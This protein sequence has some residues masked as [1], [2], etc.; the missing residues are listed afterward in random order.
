MR[1][2][3]FSKVKKHNIHSKILT[4]TYKKVYTKCT[5]SINEKIEKLNL[6]QHITPF[7]FFPFAIPRPS[8]IFDFFYIKFKPSIYYINSKDKGL[9][10]TLNIHELGLNCPEELF[11]YEFFLDNPV[12]FYK[13]A[14]H[15]YYPTKK[16]TNDK[17]PNNNDKS[18][19]NNNNHNKNNDDNTNSSNNAPP[20]S[21]IQPSDSHKLL[22]MLEEKK[23]LL[24]V[25][26][27]N[28]DGLETV[29]GVS[30]KK[31]IHAHGSLRHATC[32]ICRNKVL[33]NEIMKPRCFFILIIAIFRGERRLRWEKKDPLR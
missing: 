28:I 30:N 2:T 6:Q 32:C 7:F 4:H 5:K 11:D 20:P 15:L 24:R 29:A 17:T 22:A 18:E 33:S 1:N 25:Y 8:Q 14:K 3:R 31:V 16:N 19:N 26:T 21:T 13:F 12:P 23:M 10:A 27:Q 9:Y